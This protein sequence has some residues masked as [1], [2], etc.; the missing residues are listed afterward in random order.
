MRPDDPT[1]VEPPADAGDGP[2]ELDQ[3]LVEAAIRRGLISAVQARELLDSCATPPGGNPALAASGEGSVVVANLLSRGVPAKV[4]A[5]LED[6]AKNDFV[7]GYRVLGEL[8]RGGM[9]VVYKA[10]QKRLDRVVALKVVNPG[11]AREPDYLRRFNQEALALAR[12]N[13][14][15]IV[16]V[17]DYGEAAGRVYLALEFVEGDD[18]YK[19]L[20]QGG[21]MSEAQALRIARDAAIG[22]GH[23]HAAGIIHRDVKPANLLLVPRQKPGP[24]DRWVAKVTDLGLARQQQGAP[25]DGQ[26]TRAGTILGSPS[27]MAPEQADGKPADFRSDI[28]ALGATLYHLVTGRPPFE[29]ESAIQVIVKKQTQRLD[30]PRALSPRLG[31]GAVRVIDRCMARPPGDRYSS[32]EALIEDLER[33]LRGEDPLAPLVPEQASSLTLGPLRPTAR[34]AS[35]AAGRG[36]SSGVVAA[37][38]VA[39]AVVIS[40]LVSIGLA[41]RAIPGGEAPTAPG[42]GAAAAAITALGALAP[43]DA[44]E[45]GRLRQVLDL[46]QGAPPDERPALELQLA[47]V[48][49]RALD[50]L[51]PVRTQTLEARLAAADYAALAAAVDRTLET[52]ILLGREVPPRLQALAA[53]AALAAGEEGR[54]ERAAWARAAAAS[55]PLAVVEALEGFAARFPWSP[56]LA[57]ARARLA[58]AEAQAPLVTLAPSVEG[59]A[60]QVDGRAVG[61]GTWTG[62]LL[63]GAHEVVAEAPG[64]FVLTRTIDVQAPGRLPLRLDPQ[65]A[66]PLV[67]DKERARPVWSPRRPVLEQWRVL[68]GQWAAVPERAALRGEADRVWARAERELTDPL[69]RLGCLEGPWRLEWECLA[70]DDGAAEVRLL[71][72]ED[73]R[74]AVVGVARG[75]AYLGLRGPGGEPLDVLARHPLPAGP[76]FLTADWDGAVLV[77]RRKGDLVGSTALAWSPCAPPRL[78]AAVT[79]SGAAELREL[80]VRP[81]IESG[82]R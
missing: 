24:D 41:M 64:H 81:L 66:R 51:E 62:R 18:A 12:L 68:A 40:G 35:P 55:D 69:T 28:Y 9:G 58:A 59:A 29:A 42:A 36:P 38:V 74:A 49:G 2:S 75:E 65:P 52:Y 56:A 80:L 37:A 73:G 39:G 79:G 10:L 31:D 46:V 13:H 17:Y 25:G 26:T 72:D 82:A 34:V 61:A 57:D 43:S 33:V 78:E 15:N 19:A 32:Y 1:V 44:L 70:P 53:T 48:V 14:P 11:A 7:P 4:A 6:E 22:L 54:A 27:Y 23:A 47:S 50:A 30:D 67:G 77:V 8:G 21:P 5:E 63:V 76:V 16:Q 60:L 3:R 71:R 45:P 20:R